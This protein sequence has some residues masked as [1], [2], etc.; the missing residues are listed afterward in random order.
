MRIIGQFSY[1]GLFRRLCWRR[2]TSC[3]FCR[4]LEDRNHCDPP[5]SLQREIW[6]PPPGLRSSLQAAF[7]YAGK[8]ASIRRKDI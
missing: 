1:V 7:G 6:G 5:L 8:N 2:N 3:I 4:C